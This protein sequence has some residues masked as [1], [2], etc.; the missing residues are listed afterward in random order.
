M[1]KLEQYS[2]LFVDQFKV[3]PEELPDLKYRGI[4]LWDSLGHMML[5]E[6]IE[7]LFDITFAT[8]DVLA[9]TSYPKGIELLK[10]YDVHL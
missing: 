5:M 8:Q 4:K 6:A 10:K 1:T 9:F 2:K 7:D 3:T